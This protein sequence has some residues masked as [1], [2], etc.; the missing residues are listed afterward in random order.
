MF[1]ARKKYIVFVV[2]TLTVVA[3]S[4]SRSDSVKYLKL[5]NYLFVLFFELEFFLLA[6]KFTSSKLEP[7]LTVLKVMVRVCNK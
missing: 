2:D 3:W 1:S 6:G 4:V 7:I 5:R